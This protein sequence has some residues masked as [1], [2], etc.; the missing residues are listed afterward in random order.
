MWVDDTENVLSGLKQSWDA[1]G[2]LGSPDLSAASISLSVPRVRDQDFGYAPA[3]PV[4][5]I[6]D[7]VW[8]D[9]N[10]SGGDQ[11]T[12]GVEP[13]IPGVTLR[14]YMDH[15]ADGVADDVNGD[16]A[17]N[18]LDAISSTATDEQ[19]RYLFTSLPLETYLVQ[20]D[21]ATLPAGFTTTP[22]Y[23]PPGAS[24]SQSKVTLTGA[25]PDNRSQDFSYYKPG[26]GSIGDLV[27]GDF[28]SSGTA[29]PDAGEPG[30]GGVTVRLY[31]GSN[32]LV[33]TATTN[34]YGLYLFTDLPYGTYTVVVDGPRC[35]PG[36]RLLPPT[37]P[38]GPR[39]AARL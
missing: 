21:T 27:W 22:T 32:N 9:V 19:G 18:T 5:S 16:G 20:V 7:T 37:I 2:V 12:Q 29:T 10:N 11:S 34:A 4:G 23:Q 30:L 3:L 24:N 38:S 31:D 8:H 6:G 14:L 15:N 17:T 28:N 33:S 36:L 39:T 25:S 1:N 26:V 13:G 35:R